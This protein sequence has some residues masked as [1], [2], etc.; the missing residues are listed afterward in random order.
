M[1]A[2]ASRQSTGRFSQ[3]S[4]LWQLPLLLISLGLFGYAAYVFIDPHAGISIDQKIEIARL[5][6]R[7]ERPTAAIAQLN[8]IITPEK[9]DAEHEGGVH[10]LLAQSIDAAQAQKHIDVPE[11]REQII[12]QA[13]MALAM[14]IKDS[15]DIERLIGESYEALDKPAA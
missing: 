15:C 3:L 7:H 14:G 10:L 6:L 12:E 2:M 13:R 9:L 4:R 5:Y 8:K 11:N 1:E